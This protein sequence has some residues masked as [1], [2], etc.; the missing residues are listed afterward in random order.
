MWLHSEVVPAIP[1]NIKGTT[2]ERNQTCDAL[3]WQS[4]ELVCLASSKTLYSN[5]SSILAVFAVA[6]PFFPVVQLIELQY[7]VLHL[8]FKHAQPKMC[9]SPKVEDGVKNKLF[10]S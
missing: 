2:L 3:Q 5:A 8:C 1:D 7:A 9:H 6:T 4:T 10:I